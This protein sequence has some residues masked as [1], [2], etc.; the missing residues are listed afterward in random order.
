MRFVVV[1]GMSGGGKATAI[2]ILEDGGYYCVDNLPVRLI[3]KFMELVFMPGSNVD[4]VVLGLDVRADRPFVYVEEVLAALRQRGYDY[5]ILFMDASDDTLIKRYKETRRAHPCEPQGRVEDGIRKERE[6]LRQI[7][8]K[9]DYVFDTSSLLVRELRE[10]LIR[11]FVDN[12]KYNSLIVSVMSFGFKNGI[13]HDADLVFDVRFL[14]N[15]DYIDELKELTGNDK[16]VSD[17]VLSFP[18]TTQ[19]RKMLG[20]MIRFLIP[21]YVEEGKNQLVIAIGCTGG[22]H[23]SVTMANCLYDDLRGGGDYALKIYHRDSKKKTRDSEE[24]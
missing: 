23:R 6:I 9:A 10:E 19:F 2:K 1:T 21:Y 16:P 20:E 3:D 17:Y 13:P 5:E 22:Q 24:K 4:K 14:P 15:P 18:Q 12:E 11:V 8:S 7:K